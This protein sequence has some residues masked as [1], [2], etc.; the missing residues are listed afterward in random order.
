MSLSIDCPLLFV[1]ARSHSYDGR[2][3][4]SVDMLNPPYLLLL[5]S[6]EIVS[7]PIRSC[8]SAIYIL[9]GQKRCILLVSHALESFQHVVLIPV[10]LV[11]GIRHPEE[12]SLTRKLDWESLKKNSGISATRKH[13]PAGLN[14]SNG[15]LDHNNTYSPN[16]TPTSPCTPQ[17]NT[18]DWPR[19]THSVISLDTVLTCDGGGLYIYMYT[20]MK[21]HNKAILLQL[22]LPR[23]ASRY[24]LKWHFFEQSSEQ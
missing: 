3:W 20:L 19:T 21:I 23:P 17:V 10:N 24:C 18:P 9:F 14:Q 12:M 1:A 22:W 7:M 8:N 6:N 11:S 4:H 15:S 13:R 16:R 2:Q 5:T